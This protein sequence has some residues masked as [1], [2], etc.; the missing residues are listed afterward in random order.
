[1]S[2]L[3]PLY[4]FGALAVGLPIL[5]HLIR[6]TPRGRQ[7]FSSVMFLA[8]SPPR[9]TRRSRIEHW[10][11][12]CLRGLAICLLAA[13]FA[14]PFW[15][16]RSAADTTGGNGRWIA[17][18]LDTSA[19]MRRGDLW[20][21]ARSRLHEI[22]H[23]ASRNDRIAVYTFDDRFQEQFSW[24]VWTT[25]DPAQRAAAVQAAVN[26]ASPTWRG[27]DLGQALVT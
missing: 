24:D 17:I 15:R 22:V 5:F 25:L 20:N 16:E 2:F 11:L 21:E 18:L 13:A 1:M 12:L 3:T 8:P 19:S 27:T 26:D 10:L 7:L 6:R 14:R 9:I 4:L 23:G